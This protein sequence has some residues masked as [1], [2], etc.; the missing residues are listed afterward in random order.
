MYR[1]LL[2]DATFHNLLLACDRDLAEE[3]RAGRCR[4]CGGA[5]HAAPYPRK[6]RGRPVKLGPEHDQR[7][8]FCCALDGCRSRA[9]PPSLRFLGPKVYLAAIVVPIAIMRH[10]ASAARVQL[11]NEA[12]GVDRRTIERW[13]RWWR[14]SFTATPFWQIARAVPMPPVEHEH[15]PASLLDRFGSEDADRLIALLRFLGPITAGRS[16][17]R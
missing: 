7:L 5:L 16:R 13:R 8:S 12:I 6:P 14:D 15:L 9:T 17:A 10:G 3:A 1:E 2:A 11:M 4:Q